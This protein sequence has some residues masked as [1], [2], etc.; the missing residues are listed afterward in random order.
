M[1]SLRT[2]NRKWILTASLF[3]ALSANYALQYNPS[4]MLSGAFDFASQ[5]GQTQT[6]ASTNES[7]DR[8]SVV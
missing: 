4:K 6:E 3:A 7:A 5:A 1:K 8:K 2:T